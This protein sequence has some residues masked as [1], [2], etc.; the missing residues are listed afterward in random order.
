MLAVQKFVAAA[1]LVMFVFAG[2]TF[3]ADIDLNENYHVPDGFSSILITSSDGTAIQ[4]AVD[5][6]KA[7]GTITLSG[8]FYLKKSIVSKKKSHA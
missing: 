1:V 7:G 6:I 4:N 5:Y 2:S 8:N 3:A